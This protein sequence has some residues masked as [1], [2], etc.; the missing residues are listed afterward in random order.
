MI[1]SEQRVVVTGGAGFV[2]SYLVN[3]LHENGA[4]VR[5]LDVAR[6]PTRLPA[7]IDYRRVDVSSLDAIIPHF[8]AVDLVFHLAGNPSTTTSV[9]DPLI[10]LNRN[11]QGT[12]AVLEACR[13]AGVSKLVY[14]SSASVYGRP[15]TA[16]IKESHRTQPLFPYGVSKL[17]GERYCAAYSSMYGLPVVIARPFCIYG[18]GEDP[19]HALVEVSRYLRWHLAGHAVPVV[20]DASAKTRDF[21]HVHDVVTALIL[22]ANH[23]VSG[24]I[25]NLGSGTEISMRTLVHEIAAC[26]GGQPALFENRTIED[27]TYRLVADISK[28]TELGF[29]PRIPLRAGIME[30]ACSLGSAPTLPTNPTIFRSGDSGE[31]LVREGLV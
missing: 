20:G 13:L 23:G 7:E 6:R 30:L 2:G 16:P 10:D 28:L 22:L 3:A 26:C 5:V 19:A 12:L 11:A 25:Y 21:I 29:S 4:E 1:S 27:D 31:P 24:E 8:R 18:P 17:T 14:V 15:Q 9:L